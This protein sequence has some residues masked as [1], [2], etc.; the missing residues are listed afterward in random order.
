MLDQI[1]NGLKSQVGNEIQQKAGVSS[2][3]LDDIMKITGQVATKEVSKEMLG[4]NLETVMNLF[5]SGDNSSQANSLQSNIV[6]GLVGNFTEKLGLNKDTATT[7]TSIVIP[8]LMKMIANK[9]SETA[10]DDASPL[11]DLFNTATGGDNS[12]NPLGG[13]I[14]KTIGGFFG[15]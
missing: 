13:L 4:G 15:K 11:M 10:D 7:I 9:N 12:S 3:M 8:A 6:N 2:N 1:L 14:G 5:S